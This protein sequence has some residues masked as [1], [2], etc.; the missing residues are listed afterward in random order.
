MIAFRPFLTEPLAHGFLVRLDELHRQLAGQYRAVSGHFPHVIHIRSGA[1][2]NAEAVLHYLGEAYDGYNRRMQAYDPVMGGRLGGRGHRLLQAALEAAHHAGQQQAV[3]PLAVLRRLYEA[4]VKAAREI[5]FAGGLTFPVEA[6]LAGD[7]RVPEEMVHALHL[8]E[9]AIA[10]ENFRHGTPERFTETARDLLGPESPRLPVM[11]AAG[12][13]DQ[14]LKSGKGYDAPEV[15][16]QGRAMRDGAA[17]AAALE[18]RHGPPLAVEQ[19]QVMVPQFAQEDAARKPSPQGKGAEPAQ[20]ARKDPSPPEGPE[21]QPAKAARKPAAPEPDAPDGPPRKP[22][23]SK[24]AKPADPKL[25]GKAQEAAQAL[26][27]QLAKAGVQ[28][29]AA[30]DA[31]GKA[32]APTP[33]APQVQAD[34]GGGPPGR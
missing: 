13:M 17:R 15:L 33:A 22:A 29:A 11:E 19:A 25:Q 6:V 32:P 16:E 27:S 24:E 28:P 34:R 5:R 12:R 3:L 1:I 31:A 30:A 26:G 4:G 20:P 10:I 23:E 2:L 8:D 14:Q 18:G 21:P 7:P 9:A